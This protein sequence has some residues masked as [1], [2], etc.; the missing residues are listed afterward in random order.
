[1][2]KR[3][4][5]RRTVSAVP[6][7]FHETEGGESYAR[8]QKRVKIDYS[9]QSPQYRQLSDGKAAGWEPVNPVWMMHQ[10]EG[11]RFVNAHTV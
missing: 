11:I 6:E 8:R 5:E 1:M 9:R 10:A 4:L 7:R 3:R 2:K